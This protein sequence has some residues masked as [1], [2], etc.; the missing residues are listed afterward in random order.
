MWNVIAQSGLATA[1]VDFTS[2]LLPVAFGLLGLLLLS[3]GLIASTAIGYHHSQ[4]AEAEAER[5]PFPTSQRE[6]A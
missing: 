4:K 1:H 5:S 3:V 2:E 6:V